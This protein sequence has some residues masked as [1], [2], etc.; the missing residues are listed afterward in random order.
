MEYGHLVVFLD[1]KCRRSCRAPQALA[2]GSLF[3]PRDALSEEETDKKQSAQSSDESFEP[4]PE[5]K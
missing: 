2:N 4:Y 5:K 3:S 1:R